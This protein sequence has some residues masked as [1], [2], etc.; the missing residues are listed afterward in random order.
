MRK[1]T[2]VVMATVLAATMATP[3]FAATDLTVFNSKSEIETQFEDEAKTYSDEKGVNMTVAMSNDPVITHMGTRYASNNPYV[4]SMVDAKDVYS[5]TPDHG[6]DLSDL[7]AAKD[8]DYAITIDGKVA[9][10]PFCIEARG[11]MYNKTKIEEITGEEFK[12]EDY[13]TLD[14]FK[15]LCQKIADSGDCDAPVAIMKEDWSL[16]AHYLAQVVE[17]HDDPEAFANDLTA[18]KVDLMSDAQFTSL[19]DTFDVLKEYNYAKDD[20][21]NADRNKSEDM[22]A[23]GDVCFMFGGNWDWSLIVQS[24]SDCELGMMPVPQNT[25]TDANTKLVGGGSKYFF[26]DNS[27]SE[28]QQ[29]A[30]KDF[31]NWQA[32]DAEGQKF[33]SETCALVSP[34]KSNTLEVSDPL[35][36]S[37]K[38][39]AD[40]SALINNYNFFPDDHITK[41]GAIMQEY[42]GD[43]IDRQGLADELTDYWKSA[44]LVEH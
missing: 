4:L 40:N 19:M 43:Q 38:E 22:L 5:L 33:V 37:V 28:D 26:I 42:L 32:E 13:K 34:Y 12:P 30:A 14:A 9:A 23:W 16:S 20:A 25:D 21:V 3:A 8:T 2:A 17:E 10:I 27:V 41:A 24:E 29:Q 15:E 31:L 6:I 7:D 1:R 11:L 36:K 44:K 39:Y 18:G 35:S